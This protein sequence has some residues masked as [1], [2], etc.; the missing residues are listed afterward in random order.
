MKMNE[1]N[2]RKL[3]SK[4]DSIFILFFF[5][6]YGGHCSTQLLSSFA[7]LCT[8]FL[9]REGFTLGVR[10]ILVLEDAEKK[11]RK[12]IKK[13]SLVN[14]LFFFNYYDFNRVLI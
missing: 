12:T 3:Y 8:Y 2:D 1:M 7:K 13:C 6:L 14:F 10:D 4:V 5:Q 11:R 9:Q